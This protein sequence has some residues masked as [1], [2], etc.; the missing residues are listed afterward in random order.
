MTCED[1]KDRVL[2]Y[3]YDEL[4]EPR[5]DALEE[6]VDSCGA[7]SAAL[8]NERQFLRSLSDRAV[9]SAA[10][11]AECRQDLMR[12]VY[13]LRSEQ[14]S[15]VGGLI[16]L[17]WWHGLRESFPAMRVAWQ[18]AAAMALLAVGFY[19]GRFL[20]PASTGGSLA[21]GGGMQQSSM[22]PIGAFGDIQSVT[23]DRG[24]DEVEI[25]VEEMTRRT[26]RGA[27]GD[28]RMRS[29]LISTVRE[30]PS[31]GVRLDTLDILSAGAEDREVR[32]ALRELMTGDRNPGVR[33]RAFE[34]LKPHSSDPDTHQ[35]F[36]EVLLNDD[37][38][39]MRVQ[40][41]ELLSKN[42]DRDLV[43]LLQGLVERE[44]NNYI[45]LQSRRVLHDLNASVDRF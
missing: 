45:R 9:P 28:P 22:A 27:P 26:I 39:G 43:G 25:V 13:H 10:L 5:R 30:Y 29:L 35:A 1:T 17:A 3:L 15:Y 23:L 40:A 38:P 33:L 31:S 24:Q 11:L 20:E 32:N 16:P 19:A 14:P 36:V 6:H 42:P 2:L 37:N 34:A 44:Q 18:P 4:D 21:V 41:I 8:E 12:G 7:C